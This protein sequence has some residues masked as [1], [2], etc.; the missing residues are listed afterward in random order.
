MFYF[1]EMKIIVVRLIFGW[2]V[3]ED[4]VGFVCMGVYFVLNYVFEMLVVDG[5]VE[6]VCFKGF[7]SNV[8][9]EIVF[10]FL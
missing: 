4:G 7:V 3:G 1:F 2:L 5:F 9:G 8:R 10:V 6:D